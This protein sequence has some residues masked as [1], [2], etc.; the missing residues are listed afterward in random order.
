MIASRNRYFTEN[1]RWVHLIVPLLLL[2]KEM[3]AGTQTLVILESYKAVTKALQA[4]EQCKKS[5]LTSGMM[6]K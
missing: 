1:S 6:V 5:S 3:S 4:L 2:E